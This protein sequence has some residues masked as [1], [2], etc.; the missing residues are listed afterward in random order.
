MDTQALQRIKALF[1]QGRTAEAADA[2]LDYCRAHSPAAEADVLLLKKNIADYERAFNQ[3]LGPDPA[4][5]NRAEKELLEIIRQLQDP[6][7]TP[8]DPGRALRR[9]LAGLAWGLW[10]VISRPIVWALPLVFGVC[11]FLGKQHAES[12]NE[13]I[14]PEA[15]YSAAISREVRLQWAD[16]SRSEF[17]LLYACGSSAIYEYSPAQG[18][19]ERP[20]L[21]ADAS[22]LSANGV[23]SSAPVEAYAVGGAITLYAVSPG[24]FGQ[25]FKSILN[26]QGSIVQRLLVVA[27]AGTGYLY[28][29]HKNIRQEPA[30]TSPELQ[31]YLRD[32]GFWAQLYAG[33]K[34]GLE[35]SRKILGGGDQ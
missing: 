2:L 12:V 9:S 20:M 1:G 5:R 30:C 4:V 34:R 7:Q 6:A 15:F 32:E 14:S 28:G 24:S 27:S 21:V 10:D 25:F 26:A 31:T 22:L 16:D 33:R 23:L 11:Y 29:Y 8:T 17:S 35:V 19:R 3:G 13:R 18:L